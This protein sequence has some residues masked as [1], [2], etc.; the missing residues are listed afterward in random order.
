MYLCTHISQKDVCDG[1]VESRDLGGI[2]LG[3]IDPIW[4]KREPIWANN[5]KS[6]QLEKCSRIVG[7]NSDS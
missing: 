5:I 1:R 6:G 7:W 2:M 3:K 4:A